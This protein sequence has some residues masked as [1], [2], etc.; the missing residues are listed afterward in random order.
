[1]TEKQK[2]RPGVKLPD[3]HNNLALLFEL[4][5]L[6]KHCPVQEKA[7]I[8]SSS[9]C[10]LQLNSRSADKVHAQIVAT[11]TG[12]ILHDLYSGSGVTLNGRL[13]DHQEQLNDGDIIEIAGKKFKVLVIMQD[14]NLISDLKP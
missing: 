8:G 14:G 3:R 11:G 10:D 12:F 2:Y 9:V 6:G 4:P 5:G 7:L 13:V 1:M